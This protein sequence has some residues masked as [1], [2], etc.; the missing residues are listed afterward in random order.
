MTSLAALLLLSALLAALA[1]QPARAAGLQ[2]PPVAGA[3]G[4]SQSLDGEAW[5]AASADG[6]FSVGAVVPGDLLTDLQRAGKLGDPL[7]E[8]NFDAYD[9]SGKV[10]TPFWDR[11]NVTYS[12]SF[13]LDARVRALAGLGAGGEVLLVLDGVKMAAE[14]FLNGAS[15]GVTA[16][17]FLRMTA[18]VAALLRP[19][20]ELNELSVVFL[21]ST[22]AANNGAR[23]MACSGGWDWAP[24]TGTVLSNG[25]EQS[26]TF[27]KGI[28]KTVYLVPVPALALGQLVAQPTYTGTYPTQPLTDATAAPFSVLVTA[29]FWAARA[30]AATLAVTSQW[31]AAASTRVAFAAGD[32]SANVTLLAA[33]AKGEVS[34]WWP[35]GAG[36]HPLFSVSASLQPDGGAGAANASVTVGFRALYLVTADDSA[37]GSLSGVDGSGNQTMRLKVNGADVYARGGNIIPME[38]LEARLSATAYDRMV[39]SCADANFNV[40]RVWG[41]GIYPPEA[42]YDAADRNG[43][44]IYNDVM[45]GSDGR[46]APTGSATEA[47]ELRYQIRRISSRPSVA[48]HSMCNECGGGGTYASFVAPTVASEDVSRPLWPSCPSAGWS[49][50]VDRLTGLPNGRTLVLKVTAGAGTLHGAS[51]AAAASADPASSCSFVPGADYDQGFVGVTKNASTPQECCDLCAADPTNCWAA[52]L[53]QGTCFFK[54]TA[55]GRLVLDD[56]VTSVFPAGHVPPAPSQDCPAFEAHGPYTHGFSPSFPAVNGQDDTV[57]VNLPPT[58][59]SPAPAARGPSK[60]GMFYSEFGASVFSSF[61]SMAPTLAPAHWALWGGVAP[62]TCTGSPWGRPCIGENPLAQ[63]NY[64]C[65]NFIR[66]YFGDR[67]D[68]LNE[69]GAPAFAAQLYMCMVSQALEKKGDIEQRRAQNHWGTITWQANE[70]WPTGGWGSL[71]YGTVGFTPGQVIGGRWKPLHHLMANHLYRD[72]ISVCGDA[73]HCYLRSDD[74]VNAFAGSVA[75]SVLHLRTAALSVLKTVPVSVPRGAAAFQYF[76]L[77]SGDPLAGTCQPVAAALAAAGCAADGTDCVLLTTTTRASD[78]AVLDQNWGLLS[79]PSALAAGGALPRANVS[80]AVAGPPRTDGSVPVKVS[81]DAPALLVVLTS[82]AQ[83][84]FEPNLLTLAAAGDTTVSFLPFEGFEPQQLAESLRIEHAALY[85]LDYGSAPAPA[86]APPTPVTFTV[87]T[88]TVVHTVSRN[89]VSAGLDWHTDMEEFPA[90]N[91]SSAQVIDLDDVNLRALA[92]A[93]AP[94]HLRIGGSEG[95]CIVYEVSGS[96]CAAHPMPPTTFCANNSVAQPDAFCLQTARWEQLLAFAD[97]TGLE[98]AFGLNAMLGR[99]N[100]SAP[101]DPSNTRA[102]LQYIHDKN[103]SAARAHSLVFEFGNELEYKVDVDVYARDLLAVRAMIDAI[104]ADLPRADRPRMVMNDENPDPSYWTNVLP[105]VGDAVAAAT[106]HSYTGYGLDPALPSKAFNASFLAE[107][108]A[109]AAPMVAAAAAFTAKGGEIWVGETAMA[110]HSGR[111]GT[112]DAFASSPWYVNALGT[113]AATHRVHVRQTFVGGYYNLVDRETLTPNPDYFTALLWKRAMGE[114]VLRAS[115]SLPE[116]VLVFAH[117]SPPTSPG[118]VALAF[119]NLDA[120]TTYSVAPIAGGP[121]LAPRAE[122][123]LAPVG[124]DQSA[125]EVLLNGASSPLGVADGV[126]SPTPPHTVTDPAAPLLLAP[127]TLGF[128]VLTAGGA[129]AGVCSA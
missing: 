6:A 35:A 85:L 53:W 81:T 115:S 55:T 91:H 44:L 105:L 87:D 64:P 23:F 111:N 112:T 66:A 118:G 39:Q 45:F 30:G 110:W 107:T 19:A 129:G 108:P 16:D 100:A 116:S 24:Y 37:P 9:A 89:F 102:F 41:G 34:L 46:I 36:A 15:L 117:C 58:L 32:N 12:I 14:V 47:A 17:Q 27:T 25:N 120:T 96:D 28:W 114:R 78:G 68:H 70:I 119:I 74:A 42:F 1:A 10:Q 125:R 8:N 65:D 60:C 59:V 48:L 83:G 33:P 56:A 80:A 2:D 40:F 31:G 121:P 73:G 51:G 38:E 54:P 93:F 94:A 20:Q 97:A 98:I 43:L 7:Y 5:V 90:W 124:G 22:D 123:V 101:F 69:T 57:H 75:V 61:E 21:P 82:L 18:P 104:W 71:E 88:T 62:A 95:D 76:C 109:Q 3:Q 128:I 99:A 4:A 79:T 49:S 50:G 106:W 92:S 26:R 103:A 122:Y 113:L 84:R 29:H 52:S 72:V 63:K 11:A 86:P 126:V 67:A 77:G 13:A 127:R